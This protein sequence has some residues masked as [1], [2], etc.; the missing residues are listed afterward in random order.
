MESINY[1]SES[2][3]E[4][5]DSINSQILKMKVVKLKSLK[6]NTLINSFLNAC[7]KEYQDSKS[8][9]HKM[10]I[11]KDFLDQ[12][13]NYIKSDSDENPVHIFNKFKKSLLN[14]NLKNKFTVNLVGD[15][16]DIFEAVLIKKDPNE[17]FVNLNLAYKLFSEKTKKEFSP[18]SKFFNLVDEKIIIPMVE[19]RYMVKLY[20]EKLKNMKKELDIDENLDREVKKIKEIIDYHKSKENSL[21]PHNFLEILEEDN[22]LMLSLLSYIFKIN[23]FI[24]RSWNNDISVLKEINTEESKNF[25]IIFKYSGRVS[26]TGIKKSKTYETGGIKIG[27]KIITILNFKEH[28][29]I[30]KRLRENLESD[31]DSFLMRNYHSYLNDIQNSTS[32]EDLEKK[33][34]TRVTKNINP[35]YEEEEE[36]ED[37]EEEEESSSSSE[38]E[39]SEEEYVGEEEYEEE[40]N[41][42]SFIKN[43]SDMELF[44][45]NKSFVNPY[46]EKKDFNR[47][48]LEISYANYIKRP[49]EDV[50]NIIQDL[51][52]KVL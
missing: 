28:S 43:Y 6:F 5:F 10:V 33:Y 31:L 37:Y 15:K 34:I 14:S 27:D 38:S 25:I 39:T 30:I 12:I 17:D 40:T 18:T 29:S 23:I 2:T 44:Q 24:C 9:D 8:D 7:C 50:L 42:P 13:R 22:E 16:K 52:E 36:E 49:E 11:C 45:I 26:L 1:P 4:V 46:L 48:N 35:D 21:E 47:R 3:D 51:K 19:Q 20:E 32:I 41:I